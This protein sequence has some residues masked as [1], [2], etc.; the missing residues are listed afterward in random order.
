MKRCISSLQQPLL[1]YIQDEHSFASRD[2]A[3]SYLAAV[4]ADG[5]EVGSCWRYKHLAWT[6]SLTL[7]IECDATD[8]VH[9]K[10]LM[11]VTVG[12]GHNWMTIFLCVRVDGAMLLIYETIVQGFSCKHVHVP[13]EVD[14]VYSVIPL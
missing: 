13:L 4:L 1:S 10:Q 14:G 7:P 12:K 9:G 8:E 6:M 5:V 3:T 11:L 2:P